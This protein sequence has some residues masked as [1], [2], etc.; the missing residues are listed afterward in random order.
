MS[1]SIYDAP[2]ASA[3]LDSSNP[4]TITFDG[5]IGGSIDKKLYIRNDDS[6]FWYDEIKVQPVD[7]IAPDLV[8]GSELNHTWKLMEKDISPTTEEWALITAG[9]QL[10]FSDNIGTADIGDIITFIPFWVRVKTPR[11]LSVQTITDIVLR[12]DARKNLVDA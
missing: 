6:S 10:S 5:R 8:D 12:I 9:N 3:K 2:D 1:L 7:L 4:F 11:R